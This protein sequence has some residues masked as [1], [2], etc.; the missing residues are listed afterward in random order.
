MSS[1]RLAGT[2]AVLVLLCACSE[3]RGDPTD[4][5]RLPAIEPSPTTV[6]VAYEVMLS[7]TGGAAPLSYALTGGQPPPGLSFSSTDAKLSGTASESGE[8]SIT[9]SVRDA[10]GSEDTRTWSLKV[11][12][13]PY[14]GEETAPN[15]TVGSS[16]EHTFA[17]TGGRPPLR[18]SVVDGQLPA[19]LSLSPEGVVSGTPLG[20]GSYSFTLRVQDAS[21]ATSEARRGLPVLAPGEQTDGGPQQPTSTFPL[22]VGNWNIEWFGDA[23]YGPEDDPLQLANVQAV[24]ADA[25]VDFWGVGEIVSTA[26]FNELKKQLPGYDG[27]LSDDSTRVSAGSGSYTASEQKLGVLFKSDVVRVLRAE[28]V[29][30]DKDFDFAGRPPL[31]VDLRVTRGSSTVDV[32]ALVVHLKALA[33]AEEYARRLASS[34]WLKGYLDT[35]LPTQRAMVVGDWN[36]DVDTSTTTNPDTQQKYDTPFRNFVNDTQRYTYVTQALSLANVGSTAGRST[37]IDHQL[38][39]NE[40]AANYVANSTRVLKPLITN[41]S[42]STSDHYPIISR[43]DF[44]QGGRMLKVTAPNGGETLLAGTQYAITWTASGVDTVK[45]QYSVD[46]G[47]TWRDLAASVSAASGSYTWTVP[48]DASGGG[49]VR[50]SDTQDSTVFDVSDNTFVLNH[51]AQQVFINEYLPIPN[52]VPGTSTPDYDQMFVEL[53]N[54]GTTAVDISGWKLHDDKSYSGAEPTR[55]VFPAGTVLQ[56]GKAYVVYGGASAVPSGTSNVAYASGG[57]G[58]RFNRGVNVGSSGDVVYLVLP[59][60]T[61]QDSSSYRDTYQGVSYNRSPDAS[62]SGTWVLHNTLSSSATSPGKRANGSAF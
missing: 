41:Y 33:G 58:L 37:F 6:G 24:L 61:V 53:L 55:H 48:A 49:R 60:G 30:T 15:G 19:G 59:N 27:F 43:F 39:T 17:C 4:G 28:V 18:W 38:V 25:G 51:A 35:T 23:T 45:I 1:A 9:L 40:L 16:Y 52:N 21:G 47:G 29:L 26:Q 8:F 50:V 34:G 46:N 31:R 7:A 10:A 14:L 20:S 42:T 32:T 11:W 13:A 44:G 12:P 22:S 2:L 62:L 36:D 5:P 54:T 57:D 3:G 56:P